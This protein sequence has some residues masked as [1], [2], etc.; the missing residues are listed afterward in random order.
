LVLP[1]EIY[2][3]KARETWP[4]RNVG[5]AEVILLLAKE[6]GQHR[7]E[8]PADFPANVYDKLFELGLDITIAEGPLFPQREIKTADEAEK[9]REGNRCSAIGLA[10]AEKVL[11]ASKVKGGKIIYQGKP[12][13]SE[14]IKTVIEV[15]ILEAGAVSLNTIAA[16]GDQGCDPHQRGSG[17]L[18][19]NELIVFD[20]FPRVQKTGYWGDMTRTFLKGKANDAQRKLVATV[21]QAQKAALASVKAGVDGRT[22]HAKINELFTAAGYV[23]KETPD[24]WVGFFHGTGH[25]LGLAIHEA[26]RVNG[27]YAPKLKKGA[28]ITVEP[29]LY[30]PGIGGCRIEDVVQVTAAAPALLS[31]YHY[32]WEF[33]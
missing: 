2:L 17:L 14:R 7:F 10:A 28:V 19:A 26:P 1:L 30:Y 32:R 23:T 27:T 22:I 33:A 13:T 12:L 24:G 15:A 9:I 29:G 3:K 25:G 21:G 16:G 8:V 20:I 18:R 11:K 5:P 31:R 4:Q 6:Y